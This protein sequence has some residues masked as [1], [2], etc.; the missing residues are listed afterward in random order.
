M[1][2][3][4]L[5]EGYS[6][7]SVLVGFSPVGFGDQWALATWESAWIVFYLLV[8]NSSYL[9]VELGW[10]FSS[11]LFFLFILR[12]GCLLPYKGIFFFFFFGWII[13]N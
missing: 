7:Y 9:S 11:F 4:V 3:G 10:G 2:R 6:V 8:A 1:R 5:G 12:G 13:F